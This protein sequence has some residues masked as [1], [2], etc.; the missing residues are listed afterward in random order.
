MRSSH[1][2]YYSIE[3]ALLSRGLPFEVRTSAHMSSPCF[4]S[5]VFPLPQLAPIRLSVKAR[6]ISSVSK[7]QQMVASQTARKIMETLGNLSSPLANARKLPMRSLPGE[8]QVHTQFEAYNL[9]L[10]RGTAEANPVVYP[11]F[12]VRG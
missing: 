11:G 8:T 10:L 12:A 2:F 9:Y 5:S 4:P 7:G 6:P 1:N 3:E